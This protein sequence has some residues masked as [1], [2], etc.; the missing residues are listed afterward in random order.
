M[1]RPF[2]HTLTSADRTIISKSLLWISAFCAII[3]IMLAGVAVLDHRHLM[4]RQARS[5]PALDSPA[6]IPPRTIEPTTSAQANDANRPRKRDKEATEERNP[7][8]ERL[9]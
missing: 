9:Q 7:V 5:I 4:S 1:D 6:T 8:M 2:K 3:T